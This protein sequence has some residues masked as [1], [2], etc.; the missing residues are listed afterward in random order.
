VVCGDGEGSCSR[1]CAVASQSWRWFFFYKL[2]GG[3]LF[4][5]LHLYL[6]SVFVALF[7]ICGIF[8]LS[9]GGFIDRKWLWWR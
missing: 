9:Y 4:F 6:C 5:S 8:L 3:V 2:G 7:L 1:W